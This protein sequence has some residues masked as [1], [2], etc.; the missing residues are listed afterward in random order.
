VGGTAAPTLSSL[1]TELD[2]KIPV[3]LLPPLS[4][5]ECG[6]RLLSI[7]TPMKQSTDSLFQQPSASCALQSP[8]L[9]GLST[10]EEPG[11]QLS[12]G[13][14]TAGRNKLLSTQAVTPHQWPSVVSISLLHCCYEMVG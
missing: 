7:A 14:Y 11:P 13:R 3:Q 1:T 2:I 5:T 10:P 12:S 9:R 4:Q 6:L 8:S